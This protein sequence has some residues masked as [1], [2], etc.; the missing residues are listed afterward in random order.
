MSWDSKAFKEK[1]EDQHSFP[2]TYIF[3]FIV[4]S[5]SIDLVKVVWEEG[6]ITLKPSSK[7]KYTSV[8]IKGQMPTSDAVIMVYEKAH[9]I[10]GI[11]AL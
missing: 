9:E 6:E 4:P 7:G 11:I 5:E 3:K 10:E 1:L 8:T 2:G